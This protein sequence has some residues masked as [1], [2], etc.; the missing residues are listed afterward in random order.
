MLI[1]FALVSLVLYLLIGAV[2]ELGRVVFAAQL[3]V[4]FAQRRRD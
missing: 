3:A 4:S 2:I 1:E